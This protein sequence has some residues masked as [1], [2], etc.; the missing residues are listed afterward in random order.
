MGT[1]GSSS[2]LKWPGREADDSPPSITDV[3]VCGTVPP[4]QYVFMIWCLVKH[5]DNFTLPYTYAVT[6][7]IK[8]VHYYKG[9]LKENVERICYDRFAK[10]YK[11]SS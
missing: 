1:G 2:E 7:L 9:H 11:I 8:L 4:P 6:S 3:S 5:R 10:R